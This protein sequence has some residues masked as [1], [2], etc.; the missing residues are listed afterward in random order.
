MLHP[1]TVI[2]AVLVNQGKADH[3]AETDQFLAKFLTAHAMGHVTDADFMGVALVLR[4]WISLGLIWHLRFV[5]NFR[6]RYLPADLLL[7]L[8]N[9]M[10]VLG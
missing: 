8:K 5:V 6:D 10:V 7:G 3:L 9:L 4:E 2:N 1:L